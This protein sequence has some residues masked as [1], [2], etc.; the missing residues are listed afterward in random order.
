MKQ[1]TYI[2]LSL[3]A[4]LPA[5]YSCS[6]PMDALDGQ[7]DRRT[8]TIAT[9]QADGEGTTTEIS[10]LNAYLF[11]GGMLAGQYLNLSPANGQS[12]QL[13]LRELTGTLYFLADGSQVLT[14]PL[15]PGSTTEAEFLALS[16]PV[17][18]GQEPAR[19][20]ST[21]FDLS[22]AQA[23][24]T[25]SLQR[26]HARVDLELAVD[27]LEVDSVVLTN[28]ALS[29]RIFAGEEIANAP[30]AR[31]GTLSRHFTTAL[32]EDCPDLF[33]LYEQKGEKVQANIYLK[34]NGVRNIQHAYFPADI[35]R[36]TRYTIRV[37][38]KGSNLTTVISE[39]TDWEDGDQVQT[40]PVGLIR[41]DAQQSQ[42]S[43]GARINPA[44]DTLYLPY[45]P[46][47]VSLV[48]NTDAQTTYSLEG[49][50]DGVELTEQ[51][52]TRAT[53]VGG[54]HFR[55]TS[56]L[57]APQTLHEYLYLNVRDKDGQEDHTGRIVISIAANANT[58]S[59][60]PQW[61]P[62][63]YKAHYDRYIDGT[64][65]YVTPAAGKQ[66]TLRF[67]E[68]EDPWAT[69]VAEEDGRYRVVAGWRPN[70]IT[71]NGRHQAVSLVIA[72]NDGSVAET[73]IVSRLNYSLPVVEMNGYWWCKYNLRGD[74]R[75]FADQVS[76]ANDPAAKAG[77]S[78]T[79]Y[80]DACTPQEYLAVWGD[81]Y[82]GANTQGLKPVY[83]ND[84]LQYS[85]YNNSV[86]QN[87]SAL[88]HSQ[89]CPDGY[90]IPS[91]NEFKAIM[92]NG[93]AIYYDRAQSSYT[94]DSGNPI[95]AIPHR[96]T[97]IEVDGYT[98]PEVY[99]YELTNSAGQSI[100]LYGPGYQPNDASAIVDNYVIYATY[101]GSA[102]D[103]WLIEKK[104]NRGEYWHVSR[105]NRHTRVKF[106]IK[107]EVE[108]IY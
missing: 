24:N 64:L 8:F 49:H 62:K 63:T 50:V 10:E 100:T 86:G 13:T 6:D 31:Y 104:T 74:S 48:L 79:Q 88:P 71:A 14:T 12:Y 27:H 45:T 91:V 1:T 80:L 106:C 90:R 99:H 67:D 15:E 19:F 18:D 61:D 28:A 60:F 46:S 21:S 51:A 70:D 105:D 78:M 94:S 5:T 69:L 22:Q 98:L 66:L 97:D 89:H 84:M 85:G 108:Y 73:Y 41:I 58:F 4:L 53:E 9:R 26:S 95:V 82:Q 77:L 93:A 23:Q 3:L 102:N 39:E 101:T 87:M 68:G 17:T 29:G 35:Q 33:R 40:D 43:Q 44:G 65:G 47:D 37:L 52:S 7:A 76:P 54:N 103:N 20:F 2:Y 34:V 32:T 56:V 25:V 72:N 42:L 75:S 38:G 55:I 30:D 57:R 36:N 92:R 96:R 16:A 83:A 107:S 11:Q 59:G 81:G